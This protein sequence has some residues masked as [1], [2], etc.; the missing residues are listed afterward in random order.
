MM[1]LSPLQTLSVEL[2]IASK[3]L[4]DQFRGDGVELNSPLA[5]NHLASGEAD[6]AR[7]TILSIA[8]R[9]QTM[10]AEPVEFIRHLANQVCHIRTCSGATNSD[11]T[12]RINFSHV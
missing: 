6:N 5:V 3:T 1:G 11:D 8:T 4:S 7:R 9:L 10:L 12:H 2:A